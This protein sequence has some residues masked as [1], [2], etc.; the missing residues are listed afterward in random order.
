MPC[1]EDILK[2]VTGALLLLLLM[3]GQ[4]LAGAKFVIKPYISLGT[5]YSSNYYSNDTDEQGVFAYTAS[6]GFELGITTEKSELSLEYALTAY[7]YQNAG[8]VPPGGQD[9]EDENYIDHDLSLE[10]SSQVTER[11]K[12]ALEETFY[13]TRDPDQ[14]DTYSNEILRN[15][16]SRNEFHP[17][18]DYSFGEKFGLGVGYGY[19]TIDQ[20]EE[21]L[22]NSKENRGYL[23]LTYNLSELNSLDLDFQTWKYDYDQ[24]TPDY[25]ANQVMLYFNRESKYRTLSAGGGWQKREVDGDNSDTRNLVWKIRL[26]S[27]R[28]KMNFVLSQNFNNT[29]F[30]NEYYMATRFNA[31]YTHVFAEK[32]SATLGGYYQNSDYENSG[33][34]D[35]TYSM[36]LRF[37]YH[38][39][40]YLSFGLNMGYRLRD[41]NEPG[42]DYDDAYVAINIKF[43][44]R[45]GAK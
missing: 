3:P 29:S 20:S 18:L 25:T 7:R 33:R 2:I 27:D 21:S 17:S 6:P 45:I 4:S 11:L 26:N 8:S 10:A 24:D 23:N 39:T 38:R 31:S 40:E 19:T 34:A 42:N 32:L 30:D 9:P 35:N 37:V 5:E 12:L 15:K 28:P 1:H 22:E 14:L 44:P 13:Y 41:S 36:S 43:A 16:Y